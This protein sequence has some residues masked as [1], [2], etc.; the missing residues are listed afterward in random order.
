MK[1]YMFSKTY[2]DPRD[3]AAEFIV[4]NDFFVFYYFFG[5]KRRYYWKRI[6]KFRLIVKSSM[7]EKF[8]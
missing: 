3:K 2:S 4:I 5:H 7:K 1:K 8:Q 6:S